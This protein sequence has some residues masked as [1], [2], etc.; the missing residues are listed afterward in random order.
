MARRCYLHFRALKVFSIFPSSV[1]KPPDNYRYFLRMITRPSKVLLSGNS[2]GEVKKSKHR[3]IALGSRDLVY[4]PQEEQRKIDAFIHALS[5]Y[6]RHFTLDQNLT[7]E[8]YL[9]RAGGAARARRGAP[10]H[11][12]T[13]R[14]PARQLP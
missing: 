14:R 13:A 2:G 7:F 8:Q 6:P 4:E 9:H 1:E 5:S 11:V 10:S 12:S 3:S